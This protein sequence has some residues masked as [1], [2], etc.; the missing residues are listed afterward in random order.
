MYANSIKS[1]VRFFLFAKSR[2][3]K[4]PYGLQNLDNDL[5]RIIEVGYFESSTIL[6]GKNIGK[7]HFVLW[8]K[9]N[10]TRG[11]TVLFAMAFFSGSVVVR[12]NRTYIVGTIYPQISGIFFFYLSLLMFC[13]ILGMHSFG[14]SIKEIYFVLPVLGF[15]TIISLISCLYFRS[16]VK[17]SVVQ[18]L[19]LEEV[20][21]LHPLK[22]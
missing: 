8:E 19:E 2:L 9:W 22:P 20:Q 6:R 13:A 17:D 3:Y 15:L 1:V 10:F 21:Q 18:E 5:K 11:R 14:K 7:N 4:Y 12:K 16:R